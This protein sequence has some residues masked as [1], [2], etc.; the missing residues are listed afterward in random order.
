M[1]LERIG[2]VHFRRFVELLRLINL[3]VVEVEL[4]VTS[5]NADGSDVNINGLECVTGRIDVGD[6]PVL[7]VIIEVHLLDIALTLLRFQFQ[8]L[9]HLLVSL[10][11]RVEVFSFEVSVR[12]GVGVLRRELLAQR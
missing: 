6:L 8:L 7:L 10:V 11:G 5:R 3:E 2:E 1:S 12:H 4:V 9:G